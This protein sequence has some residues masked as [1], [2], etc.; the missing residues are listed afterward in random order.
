LPN[1][2]TGGIP[3]NL[4]DGSSVTSGT[5][6]LQYNSALLTIT[7]AQVN[8][9]LTGAVLSLSA[10]STPGNAILTFSSPTALSAGVAR[11]GGLTATVPNST[12]SAYKSK[13]LL[14]FSG[15]TFNGGAKSVVGDDAVQVVGYF[16]DTTG[17]GSLSA[18]DASLIARVASTLDG[19][20]T[21]LPGFSAFQL[22]DPA[23]VGDISG[24]GSVDSADVTLLNSTVSGTPHTQ[25]PTIP[26]GL[27]IVPTG[28]DP[29]LSVPMALQANPGDIVAVPVNI[30]TARPDGSTGMTEAILALQYDPAA[31]DLSPA[32]IHLG[33]LPGSSSGW[34][35]SSIVNPQTGMVGIDLVGSIPIQTTAGGSL[36]VIDLHARATVPAGSGQIQLLTQNDPAGQH[37]FQTGVSDAQGSFIVHTAAG[38][39][40]EIT[41]GQQ[42]GL[43][44]LQGGPAADPLLGLAGESQQ[45]DHAADAAPLAFGTRQALPLL[46][47]FFNQPS[48]VLAAA[49]K[50]EPAASGLDM[51]MLVAL[52]PDGEPWDDCVS[53][54]AKARNNS[55]PTW[56][57]LEIALTD[58]LD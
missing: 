53:T 25:V 45:A 50:E 27:T 46:D 5:F 54:L 42:D 47:I 2:A 24:N 36:V 11:L 38:E 39:V 57:E 44:G 21:T 26:V 41:M 49:V 40:S 1:S 23:I 33:S 7:G 14:H 28:P 18:G 12:A 31:F 17:D 51:A 52:A 20:S 30:D 48:P 22:A 43:V 29:V 8:T 16:G 56:D 55:E 3:L 34:Q 10:A 9:A 58:N 37:V 13:A 32:D 19:N 4:S 35:V 6:T 15:I